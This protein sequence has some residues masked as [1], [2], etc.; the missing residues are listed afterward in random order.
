MDYHILVVDDD[1]TTRSLY[2][3]LFNA[4]G[5]RVSSASGGKGALSVISEA[6]DIDLIISDIEMPHFSGI[7]FVRSLK[8]KKSNIP[9]LLISGNRDEETLFEL[10][11]LGYKDY[12]HKPVRV[13]MLRESVKSLLEKDAKKNIT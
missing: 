10:D 5:Y 8:E 12:L 1:E 6:D 9:V 7:D 4:D 2:L 13:A 11:N 3:H